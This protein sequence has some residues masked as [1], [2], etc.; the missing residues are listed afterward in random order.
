[1]WVY[2][3][4]HEYMGFMFVIIEMRVEC[5]VF[6]EVAVN[7]QDIVVVLCPRYEFDAHAP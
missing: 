1:M 4:L 5:P 3:M 7:L 2:V 6:C